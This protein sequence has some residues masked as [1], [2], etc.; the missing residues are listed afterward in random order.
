MKFCMK[1]DIPTRNYPMRF[2]LTHTSTGWNYSHFGNQGRCEP[3]CAPL[4]YKDLIG[5]S[6][7]WPLDIEEQIETIWEGIQAK[8]L[9]EAEA[10]VKLQEI[11]DTL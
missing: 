11:A 8:R 6:I 10:Q 5:Y 1:I 2:N 7:E 4:L 9:T 3:N